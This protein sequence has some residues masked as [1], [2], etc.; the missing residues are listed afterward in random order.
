[1]F[2]PGSRWPVGGVAAWCLAAVIALAP[3]PPAWAAGSSL[4]IL[5]EGAWREW[6]R[7]DR[8]QERWTGPDPR[9]AR[10]LVWRRLADGVDWATAPA[11]RTA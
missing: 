5:H 8:A 2:R 3:S 10:S 7:S 4:A 1:M 9:V 6:W 11:A